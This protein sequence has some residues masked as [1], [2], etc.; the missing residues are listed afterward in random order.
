MF[1]YILILYVYVHTD[2]YTKTNN[3]ITG[4]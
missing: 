2:K 3:K 4:S 1:C